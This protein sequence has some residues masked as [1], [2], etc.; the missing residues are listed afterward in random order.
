MQGAAKKCV[1]LIGHVQLSAECEV[2]GYNITLEVSRIFLAKMDSM[3]VSWKKM[4]SLTLI[5]S[6]GDYCLL[7]G[8]L[9]GVF[10]VFLGFLV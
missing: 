2:V 9:E 5:M 7:L 6:L 10:L 1:N 3:D 8:A 4:M